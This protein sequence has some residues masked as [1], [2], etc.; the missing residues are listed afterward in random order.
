MFYISY[1]LYKLPSLESPYTYTDELANVFDIEDADLDKLT[2]EDD[3]PELQ[4][5]PLCLVNATLWGD[6]I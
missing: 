3:I 4:D 5:I 6:D 1:N 2:A